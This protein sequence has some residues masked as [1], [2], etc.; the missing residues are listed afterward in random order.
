VLAE[1]GT[2]MPSISEITQYL[3]TVFWNWF[4]I[5]G[6]I[7]TVLEIV[8]TLT[9]KKLHISR[10]VTM[11]SAVG[12]IIIAQFYAYQEIKIEKDRLESG[13]HAL[14]TQKTLA[15][16]AVTESAKQAEELRQELRT[17]GISATLI[18]HS[19]VAG[20]HLKRVHGAL[21]KDS[22]E[23]KEM[24]KRLTTTGR[25]SDP[26]ETSYS[27]QF[28]AFWRPD[29]LSADLKNHYPQYSVTKT[30]LETQVAKLDLET[31]AMREAI[32]MAVPIPGGMH[33]G[34]ANDIKA[35]VEFA[36]FD[37]CQGRGDMVLT[38]GQRGGYNVSYASGGGGGSDGGPVPEGLERAY[39]IFTTWQP[40][41]HITSRCSLL[42]KNA[43]DITSSLRAL[44]AE[45]K[46]LSE[47]MSLNG[48]CEFIK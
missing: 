16:K 35:T 33:P 25:V 41:P 38:V 4:G 7:L 13:Q 22:I 37:K 1:K 45:A 14:E 15:E 20:E 21:L 26:R 28:K 36:Y 46:R 39:Q 17:G 10:R 24:L 18:P 11:I 40:D 42:A 8:R 19:Q 9:E 34:L 29:T 43:A 47:V 3:G 44:D 32:K 2:A 5:A 27:S 31:S 30:T 48:T 23:Y 6:A 12:L